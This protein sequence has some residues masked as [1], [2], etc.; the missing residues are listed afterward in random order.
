CQPP[1]LE[2]NDERSPLVDERYKEVDKKDLPLTE[3]LKDCIARCMP[4][5]NQTVLP[6]FKN[7]DT[8][9]IAAHGNSL[10]GIVMNLKKMSEEEIIKFNIPTGIPYVFTFDE[11][12][13]VIKDEFLADEQ[14]VK[15]LMDAVANQGKK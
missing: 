3:S 14:T 12:M 6:A 8:V 13:N 4:Y 5:F 1:A 11:N 7:H 2:E 9:L 10:R 15:K